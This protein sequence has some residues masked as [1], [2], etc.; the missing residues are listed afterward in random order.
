MK[1]NVAPVTAP[2]MLTNGTLMFAPAV[3]SVAA[4]CTTLGQMVF[5]VATTVAAVVYPVGVAVLAAATFWPHPLHADV[6]S[7]R[8][9]PKVVYVPASVVEAVVVESA[10]T[11]PD[12]GS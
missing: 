8:L 11:W 6:Q 5:S 9:S 4:V 7:I 2:M 3:P 1:V 10:T 12:V